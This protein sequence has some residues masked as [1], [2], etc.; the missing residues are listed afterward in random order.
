MHHPRV[1]RVRTRVLGIFT[2]VLMVAGPAAGRDAVPRAP[3]V[4]ESAQ[5]T[6]AETESRWYGWQTLAVAAPSI[7]VTA[8]ATAENSGIAFAGL[9]A[10][11]LGGPVV[12]ASHGNFG[13]AGASLGMNVA[14]PLLFGALLPKPCTDTGEAG[15]GRKDCKLDTQRVLPI[16]VFVG[17]GIATLVDAVFLAKEDVP[18]AEPRASFRMTPSIATLPGGISLGVDGEF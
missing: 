18:R 5:G 6:P 4:V 11:V 8:I 1:M 10:F 13:R 7:T 12:H 3:T 17:A 9:G 16:G 15:P 2:G 14:L